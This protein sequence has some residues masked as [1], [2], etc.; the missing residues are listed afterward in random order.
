MSRESECS[1]PSLTSSE[2]TSPPSLIYLI[3]CLPG[4]MSFDSFSFL[5]GTSPR[6]I[7]SLSIVV[8]PMSMG[9]GNLFFSSLRIARP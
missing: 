6:A 3:T 5:S 4:L 7:P 1:F 9:K 8:S 2:F